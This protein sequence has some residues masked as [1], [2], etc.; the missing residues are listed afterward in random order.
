MA[1]FY[2]DTHTHKQSLYCTAPDC[3]IPHCCSARALWTNGFD[4][5]TSQSQHPPA[6]T[7]AQTVKTALLTK[8]GNHPHTHTQ[9]EA[10]EQEQGSAPPPRKQ[11]GEVL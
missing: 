6:C 11:A 8:S 10:K 5:V 1:P 7:H 3:T 4:S 2:T 9:S